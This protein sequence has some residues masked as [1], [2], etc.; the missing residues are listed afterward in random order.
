MWQW[1]IRRRRR[2]DWPS[3]ISSR[4]RRCPECAPGSG[5]KL[6]AEFEVRSLPT[7]DMNRQDRLEVGHA[8][9]QVVELTD[10]EVDVVSRRPA[11]SAFAAGRDASASLVRRAAQ[12]RQKPDINCR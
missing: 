3:A 4:L 5:P 8:A 10:A 2:N 9:P 11:G 12:R 7:R 6:A 1:R